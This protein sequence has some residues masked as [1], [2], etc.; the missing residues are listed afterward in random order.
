MSCVRAID[1]FTYFMSKRR[2][3]REAAIQY[4]HQLDIHGDRAAD[5][6]PDFWALRESPDKV[7]AFAEQLILGVNRKLP[8]L[9]ERLNRFLQNFKLDRLNVVDR[10]ILRLAIYEMFYNLEVP[11]VVA[12]N[13]AIELAKRFGGQDSGKFVNGLLDKI[14]LE[15]TRPLRDVTAKAKS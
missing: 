3:G 8:E 14:K 5:L 13:E 6:L 2:E 1:L 7:R 12:I 10:N 9:D 11:P 15:V 4:L